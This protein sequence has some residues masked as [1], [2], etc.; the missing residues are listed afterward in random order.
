MNFVRK[1]LYKL[2]G[3]IYNIFKKAKKMKE[4]LI[5]GSCEALDMDL[6]HAMGE[7]FCLVPVQNNTKELKKENFGAAVA[8]IRRPSDLDGIHPSLPLVVVA[9][10]AGDE[11][12]RRAVE[13]GA[14]YFFVS[15]VPIKLFMTRLDDL[16]KAA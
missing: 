10:S 1:S 12:I 14:K 2:S 11:N 8:F 4:I 3:S 13:S 16:L 5:F 7:K 6:L 9:G 15:P